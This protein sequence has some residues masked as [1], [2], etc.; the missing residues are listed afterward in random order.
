MEMKKLNDK[1][2][3]EQ[4]VH[5]FEEEEL[6]VS[7][8]VG[9]RCQIDSGESGIIRYDGPVAGLDNSPEHGGWLGIELDEEFGDND[10]CFAGKRYFNAAAGHGVF[11]RSDR[12]TIQAASSSSYPIGMESKGDVALSM[13]GDTSYDS[14]IPVVDSPNYSDIKTQMERFVLRIFGTHNV[15]FDWDIS[16]STGATK[17]YF[18]VHQFEGGECKKLGTLSIN[19]DINAEHTI[20][21]EKEG[22][23][24]ET[25]E[26]NESVYSGLKFVL[27]GKDPLTVFGAPPPLRPRHELYENEPMNKQLWALF[28]SITIISAIFGII[29]GSII[30]CSSRSGTTRRKE[31]K[32]LLQ[33]GIIWCVARLLAIA[34]F[35]IVGMVTAG[36]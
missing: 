5:D 23:K 12:V 2:V 35:S 33:F 19:T 34:V 7:A 30:I 20:W 4:A 16:R 29:C 18:N 10:G 3:M 6:K 28:I 14:E 32:F 27:V 15:Q 13:V 8:R 9:L 25:A 24:G 21:V 36:P 1:A 31:G 22:E 26:L 11:Q 17:N